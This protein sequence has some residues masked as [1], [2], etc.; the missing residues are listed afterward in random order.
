MNIKNFIALPDSRQLW[1][2]EFGSPDGFPVLY[3]HGSPASRLEPLLIGDEVLRNLNLRIIAPDRPGIGRSTFQPNRGISDWPNDVVALANALKLE[4]FSIIGNSGGAPYAAV[5]AARIP[6][7]I[8]SVVIVSGGWRMDSPEAK[9]DLPFIN[10]LVFVFADKV[11]F[12]L[13][14]MFK[15]MTASGDGERNQELAQMKQR[16]PPADFAAFENPGRI[17][18]LHRMI[19]EA[20]RHGTRGA[21]W[22]MRLYV[23]EFGFEL[24]EIRIP[25]TLFHGEQDANAPIALT[26]RMAANLPAAQLITYTNEAHLSTLCNHVNEIAQALVQGH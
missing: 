15:M 8:H 23:R 20:M 13:G 25:I 21:V 6:E 2:A 5:C 26:R 19:R 4:K 22:D 7:R 10:R 18:A 3:F 11:P 9:A 1:Y 24:S 12:M 16:M 17:E 14:M